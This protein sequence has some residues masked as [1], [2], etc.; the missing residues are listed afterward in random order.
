MCQICQTVPQQRQLLQVLLLLLPATW[1]RLRCEGI[2]RSLVLEQKQR[3][4]QG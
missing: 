3:G 4:Q 2:C 1:A